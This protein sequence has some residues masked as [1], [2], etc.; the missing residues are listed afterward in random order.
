M[1]EAEYKRQQAEYMKQYRATK[2][3][4]KLEVEK[5]QKSSNILSDTLKARKARKELQT[6]AI[7]KAKKTAEKRT[8]IGKKGKR[9]H[10]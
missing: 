3:S 4:L 2:K 6:A 9:N 5:K 10:N 7:I 1:G 8:E